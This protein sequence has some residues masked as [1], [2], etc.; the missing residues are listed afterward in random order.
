MAK[1]K[2]DPDQRMFREKVDSSKPNVFTTTNAPPNPEADRIVKTVQL[3]VLRE[4]GYLP[5]KD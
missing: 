4:A 2:W 5:L 3:R 1:M